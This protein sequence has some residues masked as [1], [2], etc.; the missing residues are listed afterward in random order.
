MA[1]NKDAFEGMDATFM[2]YKNDEVIKHFPPQYIVGKQVD[3][4]TEVATKEHEL[5]TVKLL[6]VKNEWMYSNPTGLY[7]LSVP[8]KALRTSTGFQIVTYQ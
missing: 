3:E 5:V 4:M 7:N 1:A 8:E 2:A 6:E